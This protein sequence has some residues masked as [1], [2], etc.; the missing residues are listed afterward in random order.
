MQTTDNSQ[1]RIEAVLHKVARRINAQSMKIRDRRIDTIAPVVNRVM[2]TLLKMA[3][4]GAHYKWISQH[5]GFYPSNRM[6]YLLEAMADDMLV[7]RRGDL[8][9]HPMEHLQYD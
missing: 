5:I 3:H 4:Y 1:S 2:K 8:F 9:F 6:L 7:I